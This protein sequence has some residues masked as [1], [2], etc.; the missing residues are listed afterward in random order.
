MVSALRI[1]DLGGGRNLRCVERK[2]TLHTNKKESVS[3]Y[4]C[5]DPSYLT[6]A[7]PGAMSLCN[8][9]SVSRS[10]DRTKVCTSV[11]TRRTDQVMVG[12]SCAS[13][14]GDTDNIWANDDVNQG[15]SSWK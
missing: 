6:N 3:S 4:T 13:V 5:G 1:P 14:A 8:C 11:D 12:R 2:K 7:P 10:A 15:L 9:V